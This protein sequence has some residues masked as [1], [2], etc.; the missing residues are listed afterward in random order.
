[1][2]IGSPITASIRRVSRFWSDVGLGTKMTVIV[3]ASTLLLVSLFAYLGTVALSENTQRMLQERVVL[4]QITARHTDYVLANIKL[5]LSDAAIS[6]AWSDPG[7]IDAALER[8]YHHLDLSAGQVFLLDRAG[9]TVAAYPPTTD[10]PSFSQF[11]SVA[12]VLRGQPFAVSR[13]QRPLTPLPSAAVAAAPV[14]EPTGRL[15]GALVITINLTNPNLRT[16]TYPIGLG[17]TGYMDLIDRRGLILASTLSERVGKES[18][19]GNSL[20]QMISDH[21]TVVSA[22]H[23]CHEESLSAGPQREV[24]AFAPLEQAQWGIAVR[25]SEDEVFG[26]IRQLQI[27][28]FVFMVLAV[29]GAQVLVYFTT[30]RVILPIQ[31]LIGAT[32]RITAGDLN[33]PLSIHGHDEISIL[34]Q[35]FD[36]MRARLKD[37]FDEIQGWNRELDTRVREQT[38]AHRAALEQKEQLRDELWRRTIAAQEDERKRIS[39]ELHDETCQL[40]T[41]LAFALDNAAEATSLPQVRSMLEEMHGLTKNTLTGVHRIIFDLRPTMLDNL[42]LVPALRWYAETRL[43][44][45]GID[46][47]LLEIGDKRRLPPLVETAVFRVV[48]EAINNIA[49]HSHARHADI[50]FELRDGWAE[51]R[52]TD[53]GLGF[54]PASLTGAPDAKRGLG[55]MGMEE[56]M[57]AIGGEFHLC[58]VPGRGTAICLIAPMNEAATLDGGVRRG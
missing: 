34:T 50:A 31:A 43:E 37:S 14:F 8:T 45:Q 25:Q 17:T 20:G 6:R 58:S 16:F 12:A 41:G 39:R 7:Q 10:A 48:Q 51:I 57:S 29:A 21:R 36:A 38:A 3:I 19:H 53:D 4:A 18:D 44:E 28:V 33:T 23:D 46:F 40:L 26:S 35:S 56:R 22:C 1:M 13:Y 54:D 11:D 2:P 52:I 5:G 32:R 30:R 9:Q 49:L 42:G 55:L 27:R 47:T 15:N 24:L